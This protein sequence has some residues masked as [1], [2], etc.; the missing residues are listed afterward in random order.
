MAISIAHYNSPIG[1]LEITAED[2]W[3]IGLSFKAENK[4]TATNKVFTHCI[5]ELA[6]YFSGNRKEF[7][8]PY[9]LVGTKFQ[10]SVWH[11]LTKI[12]FGKTITYTE[13]AI[14]LGDIKCIRAAGT[15]NG[16]NPIP[17]IVPCHRVIGKNGDL[18]GFSG[19]LDNKKSLLKHEGIIRG[20]QVEIFA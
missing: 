2:E 16:R 6:S 11:N 9:K 17:I 10:K 20:E 14:R 12:P 3:I 19:G 7:T 13:L 18:V 5:S 4:P 8:V 15:A 1:K